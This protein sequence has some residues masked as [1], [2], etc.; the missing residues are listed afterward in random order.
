MATAVAGGGGKKKWER[1]EIERRRV[2]TDGFAQGRAGGIKGGEV[3]VFATP[4]GGKKERVRGM[5]T[6]GIISASK[7]TERAG[8]I[9]QFA[10]PK[11]NLGET[12][13]NAVR[14]RSPSGGGKQ[15]VIGAMDISATG[16][17]IVQ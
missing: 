10:M 4:G 8:D 3:L 16:V 13:L 6:K 7:G 1:L 2:R 9:L 15:E 5:G 12:P 11:E 17:H 14:P